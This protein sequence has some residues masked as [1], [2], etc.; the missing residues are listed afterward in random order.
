[1]ALSVEAITKE[2][3]SLP[4]SERE[5]VLE[6]LLASLAG[7]VDSSSESDRMAEIQQRREAVRGGKAQLIDG[8][9]AMRI[10]RA[11]LRS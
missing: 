6:D 2:A 4:I 1:M 5:S 11:A 9:E 7:E 3:L 8:E 10:V